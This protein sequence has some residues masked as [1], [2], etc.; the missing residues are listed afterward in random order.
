MSNR[1]AVPAF[2]YKC[3]PIARQPLDNLDA[4]AA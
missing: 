4:T 3:A 1:T 2:N